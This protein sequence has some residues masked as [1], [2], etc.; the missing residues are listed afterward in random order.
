LLPVLI[1]SFLL[2]NCS[3]GCGNDI[4]G[5]QVHFK[6]DYKNELNTFDNYL[7]KDLVLDGTADTTIFLT[8][9]EKE[10][11]AAAASETKFFSLPDTI[12]SGADFEQNPAPGPQML[13]IKLGDLDKTVVWTIPYGN[14]PEEKRIRKMSGVIRKIILDTPEYKNLPPVKGGYL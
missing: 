5:L 9:E 13:R 11:I 7:I 8:S 12:K 6:Y 1:L 10:I 14:S 4:T 3:C 2:T